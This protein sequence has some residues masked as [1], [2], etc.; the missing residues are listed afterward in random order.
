MSSLVTIGLIFFA[1]VLF[2]VMR[3][4]LPVVARQALF[5]LAS[6]GFY[7][8]LGRWA[9]LYL[10]ASTLFN[11]YYGQLLKRR[12]TAP[13]LWVGVSANI[14][15]LAFFKYL[16]GVLPPDSSSVL[17]VAMPLGISFWTF[18]ALSYL[19]DL[20]REEELDPSLR[21][22]ALYMAFAPTVLSGPI[23]RLGEMLPQF[24]TPDLPKG[25]EVQGGLERIW[26]GLFMMAL[27]R[28]LGAG[29]MPNSGVDAGFTRSDL[30][31]LDVW[32]LAVGYGMQLF[33]DFAGYSHIVIGA[34]RVFGFTLRE[35]F[36]APYTSGSP[37]EFWT[38][39]HMSL[40]FW[41]RDYLFL[42]LATRSRATWWRHATLLISMVVFGIWHNAKWTFVCW[43]AYHGLLLVVH[44]IYQKFVADRDFDERAERIGFLGLPYTFLAICL[45]W[46]LFRA[47]SL[48]QAGS[49]FRAAFHPVGGVTLDRSF[50]WLVLAVVAGYFFV[51][52]LAR[53]RQRSDDQPF[54]WIPI[55]C[56]FVVYA[57]ITYMVFLRVV[58][59]RGFVYL[60]F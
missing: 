34:A 40:S 50:V 49:M 52:W 30:H 23:C 3:L 8:V 37:S 59:A 29:I 33:F 18:Q 10:V 1:A 5:L 48:Q 55:E 38:R 28:L 6:Y 32:V 13:V 43:G 56:R 25:R 9:I 22:F 4:R 46:I 15:F 21:E 19:F 35:N 27:A 39:W 11:F 58:E 47:D 31:F 7:F 41:I 12:L 54:A 51:E 26:L 42:P 16:P 14:L 57:V 60:Q 44:R 24:R 36:D 20:Y 17:R 45:G 53:Y 2:V